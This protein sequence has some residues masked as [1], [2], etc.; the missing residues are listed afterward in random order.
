M[1]FDDIEDFPEIDMDI[2]TVEKEI[3]KEIKEEIKK[4]TD[5][6]IKEKID[7]DLISERKGPGGVDLQYI[8]GDT[9]INLLNDVFGVDGWSSQVMKEEF[10]FSNDTQITAKAL[11][12]IT[13][14]KSGIFHE[15]SGW[16][17]FT[18]KDGIKDI[19]SAMEKT[20]KSAITDGI[21]RS[22]C[23]FGNK[24][25]LCLRN[26]SYLEEVK[27]IRKERKMNKK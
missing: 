4:F 23:H 25:G 8:S 2:V 22:A 21:K 19:G 5:E 6:Q 3:K 9:C 14:R 24:F 13:L 27:R 12:R 11:I 20:N 7:P 17:T 26:K 1:N 10:P 15:D 18:S 16:D